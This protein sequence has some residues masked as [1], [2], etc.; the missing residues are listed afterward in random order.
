M[1][2]TP[3]DTD[4]LPDSATARS[5]ALAALDD[6]LL[7]PDLADLAAA[8]LGVPVLVRTTGGTP[9]YWLVPLEHDDRC[10]GFVRVAGGGAIA[11]V[12]RYGGSSALDLDADAVIDRVSN[13]LADGEVAARPMLVHDGPPGREAW[14]LVAS[15]GETPRRRLFVTPTGLYE[16]PADEEIA[17]GAE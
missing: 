3:D 11:A 4:D 1:S 8:R 16:R 2:D 13:R 6:A 15:V 5:A 9:S 14:M 10:V 17:P 7:G 12:G